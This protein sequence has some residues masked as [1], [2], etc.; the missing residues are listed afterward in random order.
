MN[1]GIRNTKEKKY[2]LHSFYIYLT[3]YGLMEF[4]KLSLTFQ[5]QITTAA[6]VNIYFV[7]IFQGK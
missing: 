2:I 4:D 3:F 6:D 7:L 1:N 5:A